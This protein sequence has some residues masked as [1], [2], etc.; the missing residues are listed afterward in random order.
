MSGPMLQ[1]EAKVIADRLGD[2]VFKASNGWLEKWKKRYNIKEMSVA[3]EDG[4]DNSVTLE[5]WQERAKELSKGYAPEDVWNMDETG[6]FWK[7]LP[8]KSLSES[9]RRCRGGKKAKQRCTWAFFVNA[10]GGKEEPV[11]IGRSA[12]PRC[13]KHLKD[14]TRLYK[15]HY[16]S[17]KKAWMRTEVMVNILTK[18]NRRV[19]NEGRSIILFLD[20]APC[21]PPELKDQFSHIKIIFLPKNTTSKT[22]PLDA[23]I[24]KLWKVKTRRKLLRHVCS[25]IGAETASE[26]VK[27]VHLLQS[28]QWGK[29]AWDEIPP[30]TIKK[31]FA[32]VGLYPEEDH[33]DDPFEG[34]ETMDL[35]Q[36]CLKL[37]SEC[38][39]NQYLEADKHVPFCAELIDS[40]NPN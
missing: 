37:S 26:I 14:N 13:F 38:S 40:G 17:N 29:Q 5:S 35:E 2:N 20:N 3:G 28:I 39:A 31:C 23:G 30:E 33:D 12:K 24:I 36:M 22:Q 27:S 1:E 10:S 19:R 6:Q 18:L 4:D 25:K 32:K 9:G 8:N 7:A 21:H 16:F 34:E 15:C 11:V